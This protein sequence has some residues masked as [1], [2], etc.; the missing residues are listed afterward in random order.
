LLIGSPI[1]RVSTTQTTNQTKGHEVIELA[2]QMGMPLMPWQEYVILDGCKVKPNG[3]WQ[4]KTNLL[5]I[6]RQNGKTTLMKFRILAGMFLWDEK[7]Q[8]ATAQNR[9]VALETFRSVCELIDSQSWLSNKVKS[10]TRANGR[11]EIELRN[12][13]RYKIIAPT[14][15]AARG[16]SAN[17]VYLD[18]ARMHKTTDSFAALAYTMQAAK[19]PSLWAF[20]NAGDI[21][22]VLLNQLRARALHKIE[23]NTDDD[24]AYWEWSA[25]PGL[26]LGDRK[27]WIQANP[28]LGH[29][30]TEETLQ[31]RMNDNPTIIQTEML[32]QFVDA[33]QSPW[34]P[35]DW[36]SAQNSELKLQP[37]RPTWIAVEISPDRTGFAIIG[38]QILDDKSIAIGLMDMENQESSIDDLRIA[39]RIA[40]WSKKYMAESV[41]L[42]K[43]SGDSVAAKLRMGGINAEIITGF[44]YFQA[45]DETL[46]SLAGGRLTHAGQEELTSAVNACIKKTTESGSWYI[47]RK[48]NAIAAIAMV[49]A[50]HK[51]TERQHSGE[52]D[53]LVS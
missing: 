24:I 7:L 50:V 43:F 53:I 41:I 14:P 39:D 12:G 47:S 27:G 11:E 18:E 20:S 15:G 49:L 21:T 9:D 37:D 26:K 17:T 22:S 34:N 13:C 25:Q 44:K 40:M 36:A 6:S 5:L 31:S 19:S 45:C 2:K 28:A 8:I 35:G 29:T 33:V 32:C 10:I 52:F 30:I 48:K 1:P 51:A 3:E 42:N 46:S 16:L 38:A 23:N 4:S